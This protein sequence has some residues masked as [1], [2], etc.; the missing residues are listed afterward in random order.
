MTVM[1]VAVV[2]SCGNAGSRQW[3]NAG[4][5]GNAGSSSIDGSSGNGGSSG[6]SGNAGSSGTAGSSGS[7]GG[8]TSNTRRMVMLAAVVMVHGSSGIRND[9]GRFQS[10]HANLWAGS[11]QTASPWERRPK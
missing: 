6:S 11:S 4:S 9:Q 2:R 7:N 1:Q 5:S 3:Y 8:S 10:L